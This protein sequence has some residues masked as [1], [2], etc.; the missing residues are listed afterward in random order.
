MQQYEHK[1]LMKICFL[2]TAVENS[3]TY[4]KINIVQNGILYQV[5]L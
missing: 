1:T 2:F 5:R 3:Q 4:K